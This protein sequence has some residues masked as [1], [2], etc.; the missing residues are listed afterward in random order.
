MIADDTSDVSSVTQMPFVLRYIVHDK[1][2]ERFWTFLNPPQQNAQSLSSCIL[3]EMERLGLNALNLTL[4]KVIGQ[5]YDGA[6]V[7]RGG[8]N[9]VHALIRAH[10]HLLNLYIAMLI[11][12]TL[13]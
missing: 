5:T 11:S 9:G 1:P 2:V 8:T 7:M 6:S 10:Y 3:K 4:E 12:L 13:F